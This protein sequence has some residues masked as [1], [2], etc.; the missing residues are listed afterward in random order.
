ME[1]IPARTLETLTAY[2]DRGVPPGGFVRA[3]LENDFCG[4]ATRADFHNAAALSEI[5]RFI[6]SSIPAVAWGSPEKVNNWLEK[7]NAEAAVGE[8]TRDI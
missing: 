7:H 6:Y 1:P 4:A 3:C 5:A 8:S 2:R